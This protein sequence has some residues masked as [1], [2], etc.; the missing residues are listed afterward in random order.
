MQL[1]A[2]QHKV[3]QLNATW[4]SLTQLKATW[5]IQRNSFSL[6]QHVWF[7]ST[8]SLTAVDVHLLTELCQF[9]SWP[10]K[11]VI[12]AAGEVFLALSW[13]S[14]HVI[15]FWFLWETETHHEREIISFCNVLWWILQKTGL[16]RAI[17]LMWRA[18]AL[19]SRLVVCLGWWSGGPGS[20]LA[21]CWAPGI[22]ESR[23]TS[24]LKAARHEWASPPATCHIPMP[25]VLYT[26]QPHTNIPSIFP[27][28]TKSPLHA[29]VA[30]AS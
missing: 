17:A 9:S 21:G 3:T 16:M 27:R 22:A 7:N 20:R 24:Q 12:G 11:W 28:T 4:L 10:E 6:R 15:H 5:S 8:D 29:C 25:I 2:T 1:N 23:L 14:N 18:G 30:L 19:L 13:W 26:Q